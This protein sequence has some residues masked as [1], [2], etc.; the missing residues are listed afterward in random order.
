MPFENGMSTKLQQTLLNHLPSGSR[1]ISAR[2]TER[3]RG[4]SADKAFF[5]N[6][7]IIY[8]YC[9]ETLRTVVSAQGYRSPSEEI[10]SIQAK[11]NFSK[12]I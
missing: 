2:Y 1:F 11:E 9:G 10:Q 7:E 12:I 3:K 5:K 4:S 8:D 6:V